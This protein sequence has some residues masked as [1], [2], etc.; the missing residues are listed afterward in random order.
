MTEQSVAC[1]VL[2]AGAGSRFRDPGHKL[3]AM[4]PATPERPQETVASRAIAVAATAAIGPVIVVTGHLSA[5]E[6]GIAPDDRIDTVANPRWAEGQMTSVHTGIDAARI[7]AASVVVIGLADQP[8]VTAEAWQRVAAAAVDG[9][10][11]AVASYSGRRANPVGLRSE[12]WPLLATDGDEGARTLMRI[13][14]D[15]VVPVSCSGSPND[16][17]TVEDLRAWQNN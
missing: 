4:L 15:L 3:R 11:I 13:R 5:A 8:G 7:H 17:D 10:A 16:I 2:A 1:V 14:E 9:A 6:L 12:V